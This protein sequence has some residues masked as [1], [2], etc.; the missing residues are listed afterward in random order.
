MAL[1]L[2]DGNTSTNEERTDKAANSGAGSSNPWD[3]PDINLEQDEPIK[4]SKPAQSNYVPAKSSSNIGALVGKLIGFAIVI[5]VLLVVAKVASGIANPKA[6]DIT[7][8]VNHSESQ[9]SSLLG[10]TFEENTTWAKNMF[11]YSGEPLT[12]HSDKDLGVVYVKGKQIG[13]HINSKKYEMFGLQVGLGEVDVERSLSQ[14]Y[15]YTASIQIV[16]NGGLAG[17]TTY[18][19]VN[20]NKNDCVVVVINNTTNRLMAMTYYNNFRLIG[21]KLEF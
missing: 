11:Q 18:Y 21:K 6:T 4:V 12:I 5:V 17:T 1:Q 19:Y 9:L 15:Q 13:V 7:Q 16:D 14:N 20:E 2:K 10:I 3:M 8:Y